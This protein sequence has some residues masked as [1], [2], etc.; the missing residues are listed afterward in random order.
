MFLKWF[1]AIIDDK[2]RMET[3]IEKSG[4]DRTVVRYTILT[5][6]PAKGKYFVSLDGRRLEKF[7]ISAADMATFMVGQ[8]TDKEYI[9]KMPTIFAV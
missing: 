8:L 7:S 6:K 1:V 4:L 5:D 9:R 2:N 3:A